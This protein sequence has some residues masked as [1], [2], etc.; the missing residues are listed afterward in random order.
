M[1]KYTLPL[2]YLAIV[3]V[4]SLIAFIAYGADK[5]KAKKGLYRTREKTLLLL[6]FF[7][8]APGAL[9]GMK[10]FHH[11]TKHWYFR[12]VNIIGLI[13]QIAILFALLYV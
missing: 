1:P 7:F 5:K 3:A 10:F 2:I 8:G 6:G 4:M 9:I 11:K 13:L 12:V